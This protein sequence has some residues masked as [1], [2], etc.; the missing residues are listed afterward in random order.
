MWFGDRCGIGDRH[1]AWTGRTFCRTTAIGWGALRRLPDPEKDSSTYWRPG[2]SFTLR[3]RV[4]VCG[5]ATRGQVPVG[6]GL[7]GLLCCLTGAGNREFLAGPSLEASSL[8]GAI[9]LVYLGR[10][11]AYTSAG[12]PFRTLYQ[13]SLT[14]SSKVAA[15]SLTPNR[16]PQ[17][18]VPPR[19]DDWFEL[20]IP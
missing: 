13:G 12:D 1:P 20:S 18:P 7:P 10:Q 16:S 2:R 4:K 17:P 8:G 15:L 5:T 11:R 19:L 3:F 14:R 9:R 6:L